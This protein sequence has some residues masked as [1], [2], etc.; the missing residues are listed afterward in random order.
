MAIPIHTY[1]PTCLYS[2]SN[3]PDPSTL[4]SSPSPPK[5]KAQFFYVSTL[6]IDDLLS[7]LS[8]SGSTS[9]NRPFSAKDNSALEEAWLA[10]QRH[11]GKSSSG[12][13]TE[14]QPDT[15]R[16]GPDGDNVHKRARSPVDLVPDSVKRRVSPVPSVIGD[17]YSGP[18]SPVVGANGAHRFVDR[19]RRSA[20]RHSM[21]SSTLLPQK[22]RAKH[23]GRLEASPTLEHASESLPG[24]AGIDTKQELVPVGVSRLHQVEL[25]NLTVRSM[26]FFFLFFGS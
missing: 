14:Q 18:S 8:P 24:F 3:E 6:S 23:S 5:L 12:N 22:L 11:R 19:P 20:S 21:E 26:I 15:P 16:H 17:D 9:E 4:L 10:V 13:A 25:P 2:S 1:G 7:P